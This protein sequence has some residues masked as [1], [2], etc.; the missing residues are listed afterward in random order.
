[1]TQTKDEAAA[2]KFKE[3]WERLHAGPHHQY[4]KGKAITTIISVLGKNAL[5]A[6]TTLE[7]RQ[8]EM[9]FIKKGFDLY[10]AAHEMDF[11][12][13]LI[14]I[15]KAA[16]KGENVILGLIDYAIQ[17]LD[18]CSRS[19]QLQRELAVMVDVVL[20]TEGLKK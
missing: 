9:D 7:Q 1:M 13:R 2:T 18:K 20:R 4:L 3:I 5:L 6:N 17:L 16:E 12:Y 8:I 10:D 19:N 11:A 15:I 14:E